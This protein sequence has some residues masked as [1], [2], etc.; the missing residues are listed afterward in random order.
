MDLWLPKPFDVAASKMREWN[1]WY[2]GKAEDLAALYGN[3]SNAPGV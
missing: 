2:V 1:A 3:R